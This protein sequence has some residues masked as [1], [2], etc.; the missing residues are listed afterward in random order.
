MVPP[1]PVTYRLS[2]RLSP[3]DARDLAEALDSLGAGASHSSARKI[4]LLAESEPFEID[5]LTLIAEVL[6]MGDF[7][8]RAEDYAVLREEVTRILATGR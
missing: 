8:R 1:T 4:R 6:G 3:I 7:A 2:S 5:E